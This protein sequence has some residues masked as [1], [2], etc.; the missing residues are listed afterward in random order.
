MSAIARE[1]VEIAERGSCRDPG[2]A[3]VRLGKRP[4]IAG[5]RLGPNRD[6]FTAVF[7]GGAG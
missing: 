3:E 2:G 6:P 4:A 7:A 5:T 1:T